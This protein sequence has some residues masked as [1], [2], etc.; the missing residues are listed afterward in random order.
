MSQLY[1]VDENRIHGHGSSMG[2][3]GMLSLGMRYPNV[4]AAVYAGVPMTD[5]AAVDGSGGVYVAGTTGSLNFP[6]SG[7]AY[8]VQD[9]HSVALMK[10]RLFLALPTDRSVLVPYLHIAAL[11]SVQAA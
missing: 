8:D 3:S 7:D 4:F 2:G 10:N 6:T 11:E 9:P 5:Y 1:H